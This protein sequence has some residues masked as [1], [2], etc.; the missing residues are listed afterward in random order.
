MGPERSLAAVKLIWTIPYAIICLLTSYEGTVPLGS[1]ALPHGLTLL[2][3]I[4]PINFKIQMC[5]LLVQL[6]H[7]SFAIRIAGG[8]K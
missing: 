8:K 3:R 7:H 4:N 6:G 5:D 1:Y 2:Y